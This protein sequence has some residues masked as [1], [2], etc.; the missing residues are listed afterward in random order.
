MAGIVERINPENATRVVGP[1]SHCVVS[2]GF[3]FTSGAIGVDP[4]TGKLADG[5]SAQLRQLL[6]NLKTLLE[7]CGSSEKKVI[8]ATVYLTDLGN[9]RELNSIYGE[10]FGEGNF[11]AR[12]AVQVSMLPAG[13][14]VE[15]DLVAAV[16]QG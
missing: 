12:S 7:A 10:F 6:S 2:G 8:K 1:Y 3:L 14:L 13:A 4:K 16:S 9:Y 15:I 11:P 5:F